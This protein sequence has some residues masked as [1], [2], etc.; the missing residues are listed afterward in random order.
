MENK[1]VIHPEL[2]RLNK[3]NR[4]PHY[5]HLKFCII[6]DEFKDDFWFA[7]KK[8]SCKKCDIKEQ[9][10]IIIKEKLIQALQ[11]IETI[12]NKEFVGLNQN[13]NIMDI[14]KSILRD[15]ELYAE[16]T[17]GLL[18]VNNVLEIVKN[19]TVTNE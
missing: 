8:D 19:A 15:I 12:E 16:G 5:P 18:Y 14:R 17:S 9:K 13:S 6:C 3:D 10:L 2:G 7:D 4:H 11:I 1:I